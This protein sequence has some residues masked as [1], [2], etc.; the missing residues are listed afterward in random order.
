MDGDEMSV[1]GR[2][3]GYWGCGLGDKM[4]IYLGAGCER[5]MREPQH[6]K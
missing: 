5:T 4:T 3:S 1:E 2:K 6:E